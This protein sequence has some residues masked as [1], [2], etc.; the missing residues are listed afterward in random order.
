MCV[1]LAT[2][3]I[4]CP[5]SCQTICFRQMLVPLLFAWEVLGELHVKYLAR[6]CLAQ[7]STSDK[8]LVTHST[9]ICDSIAAIIPPIA[10]YSGEGSIDVRYPP[11]DG[12]FPPAPPLN[13]IFRYPRKG[14][15]LED[16]NLLKLRSLDSSC[17]FLLSDSSIWG[18][19]TQMLQ[20]LWSQGQ[21]GFQDFQML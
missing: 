20:M 4:T 1:S 19:W 3:R 21:N 6:N 18:E 11:Q 9:A 12:P 2:K 17:P 7:I 15:Y 5:L 14:G 10:P 8:N 16:R 13:I